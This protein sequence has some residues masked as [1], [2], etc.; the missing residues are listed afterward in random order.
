MVCAKCQKLVNQTKLATPD[1]KNKKEMYYG[2]SASTAKTTKSTGGG[3]GAGATLGNSG[4]GKVRNMLQ[5]DA[6]LDTDLS[7]EQATRQERK[8]PVCCLRQYVWQ[9]PEQ[10]RGW[11]E[12]LSKVCIHQERYVFD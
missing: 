4:I 7:P 8:E 6:R 5:K 10:D 1:V 3:A 11:K 2:S 12:V 9:L